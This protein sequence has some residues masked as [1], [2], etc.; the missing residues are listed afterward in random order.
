MAMGEERLEE[1]TDAALMGRIAVGQSE[2]VA[3]LYARYER[4]LLGLL[5][6][7]GSRP[8]AED[9]LQETWMRVVR[10]ARRY[11]PSQPFRS[12]LFQIA[13]NLMRDH[14]KRRRPVEPDAAMA[15]QAAT[16]PG[17]ESAIIEK[18]QRD[19]LLRMVESLPPRLAEAVSLRFFEELT[20]REIA[21]RLDIPRGTVKSRLHYGLQALQQHYAKE[22]TS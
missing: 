12:W 20:E 22:P 15:E 11:D 5:L 2:A 9:L 17:I 14:W 10:S 8:D 3:P 1:L 16:G 13:W 6:R 18:Q 21:E 7:A 19:A 4:P